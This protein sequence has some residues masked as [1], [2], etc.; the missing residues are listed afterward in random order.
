MSETF[1]TQDVLRA[2]YLAITVNFPRI[3]RAGLEATKAT[4]EW[5]ISETVRSASEDYD[6][7]KQAPAKMLLEIHSHLNAR[8]KD[9]MAQVSATHTGGPITRFGTTHGV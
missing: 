9:A 5:P 6:R 1:K 8:A 7:G 3:Y 2:A 4:F